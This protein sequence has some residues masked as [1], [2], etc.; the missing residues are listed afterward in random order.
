ML[1][2]GNSYRAAVLRSV[3]GACLLAFAALS[4]ALHPMFAEGGRGDAVG[5]ETTETTE[6][7]E[8]TGNA[9]NAGGAENAAED[10]NVETAE[11]VKNAGELLYKYGFIRGASE[12]G[13][14]LNE[15]KSLT[16]VE[17]AAIAFQLGG[18]GA[19]DLGAA[20]EPEFLDSAAIPAWAKGYVAYSQK[21]G[22]LLGDDHYVFDHASKVTGRQLAVLLLRMLG[23]E[24]EWGGASENLAAL[25]VVMKDGELTRGEAFD[26]V[27]AV[28]SRPLMQD[29]GVLGVALGKLTERDVRKYAPNLDGGQ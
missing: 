26:C 24:A 5:V 1:K 2:N 15:E 20:G 4:F 13:M 18:G 12:A 27:W 28:L 14:V 16:R 25:G 29:G 17:L 19:E 23:R 9:E 22:L 3:F 21:N 10:E 6:N 8:T 11:N 7:A